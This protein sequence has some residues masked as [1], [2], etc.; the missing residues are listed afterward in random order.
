MR[1]IGVDVGKKRCQACVMD[2]EGMVLDE[3]PFTNNGEGIQRLLKHVGDA[4]CKAVIE[5]TGNLWLRIY[6]AL[7]G[8][9]VEVK[10]ANPYKTKAIASARIKTDRLSARILAHLLRADLIAEC[11]VAPREVRQVRALLRQRASLV[12]MRT[13]VKNRVHSHLDRYGHGSPWS[14]AF[15][16]GGLMWLRGLEL[17]PVDRCILD[18]HL[19]HMECLNGEIGFLDSRIAGH[20]VENMDVVLLMTL[21]GIDYHSAT[22]LALEIGDISRFPSPK[23]LVSWLGLC[24]SLYQSGNTLVLGRMKKD[25]NGRARWV[26]IQAARTA[27]R[28]DPRMRELYLRVAARKGTGKAAVRVAN[29]MAVIIWH[30]LTERRPYGQVKEGLYRSKLKRM[31]R[32]AS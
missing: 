26:L 11:Y 20:A 16:A 25:S 10:L 29:K 1:Y 28:T 12:K 32:V 2:E 18:S 14:D 8:C 21:T 27:S 9:G 7:E 23:H 4:E 13:M 22:L 31:K 30:M 5:S 24:P 3:F 17:E 15:G 19:R 6:E